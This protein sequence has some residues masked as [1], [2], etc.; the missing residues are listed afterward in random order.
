MAQRSLAP[1]TTVFSL[2]DKMEQVNIDRTPSLDGLLEMIMDGWQDDHNG[3]M[4]LH[5]ENIVPTVIIDDISILLDCGVDVREIM[6][7]LYRL[8]VNVEEVLGLE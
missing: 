1:H 4:A 5:R 3:S 6:R 8:R 7:F 2:R